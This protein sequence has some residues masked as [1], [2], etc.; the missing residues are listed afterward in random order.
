MVFSFMQSAV[1]FAAM[2]YVV[3]FLFGASNMAESTMLNTEIPAE[4]RAS[5]LSFVSFVFQM[6]GIIAPV[7]ASLA[8]TQPG[9]RTLWLLAGAVFFAVSA[10]IGI[11][12]FKLFRKRNAAAAKQNVL[13]S[14]DACDSDSC[15]DT[16]KT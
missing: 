11:A 9:I 13:P 7:T 5:L 8:S 12:L 1:S 2:F 10:V 4:K 15:M 16:A 3:Y 6:G 14:G